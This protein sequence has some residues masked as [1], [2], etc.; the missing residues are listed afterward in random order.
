MLKNLVIILPLFLVLFLF[1]QQFT[2]CRVILRMK[3]DGIQMP[4]MQA[5]IA[6][7]MPQLQMPN[8]TQMVIFM[9]FF[10]M[11]D[12][13]LAKLQLAS[14]LCIISKLAFGFVT[15]E[16]VDGQQNILLNYNYR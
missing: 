7:N 2:E 3:R 10:I 12:T 14:R 15:P 16:S 5:P 13:F 1:I 6:I 4:G 11:V 8:V 9:V